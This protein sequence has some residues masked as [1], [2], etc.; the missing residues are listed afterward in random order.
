MSAPGMGYDTL[1]ERDIDRED[2]HPEVSPDDVVP[3][4]E[5]TN[6]C[7]R[8]QTKGSD[9]CAACLDAWHTGEGK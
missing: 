2:L 4:G 8:P 1:E 5:C 7:G 9:L 3:S 6:G